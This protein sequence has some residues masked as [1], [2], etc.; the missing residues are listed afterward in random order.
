MQTLFGQL[1]KYALSGA[2]AAVVYAACYLL[3]ANH[4]FPQG[5][6]TVAVVPAF[7]ISLLV[8]FILHSRWTFEGHSTRSRG[9]GMP[10]RFMLVQGAGL[11]LNAAFTY[12]VTTKLGGANWQALI[13]CLTITPLATFVMQRAWVFG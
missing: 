8:S 13:P 4:V 5:Y 2:G 12:V 7:L 3:F 11:L 1:V 10:L 6:A 9:L